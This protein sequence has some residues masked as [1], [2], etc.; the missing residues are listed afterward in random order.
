MIACRSPAA[1]E[2]DSLADER[3]TLVV[4]TMPSRPNVYTTS[5]DIERHRANVQRIKWIDTRMDELT[6]PEH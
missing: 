2:F 4:L 3:R 5:R 6:T 1:I